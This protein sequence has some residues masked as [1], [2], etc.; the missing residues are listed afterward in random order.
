MNTLFD[1]CAAASN[2]GIADSDDSNCLELVEIKAV[3]IQLA[4]A[5]P[6]TRLIPMAIMIFFM[7]DTPISGTAD[8]AVFPLILVHAVGSDCR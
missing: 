5:K 7:L 3:S 2:E 4:A 1:G 8:Y 6:T